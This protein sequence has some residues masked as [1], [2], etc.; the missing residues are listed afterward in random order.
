MAL[1][2]IVAALGF[3]SLTA[4][5]TVAQIPAGGD[6]VGTKIE[7]NY[8]GRWLPAEINEIQTREGNKQ[9][10]VRYLEDNT[11][12]TTSAQY[13]RPLGGGSTKNRAAKPIQPPVKGRT[14]GVIPK[15]QRTKQCSILHDNDRTSCMRGWSAT[16]ES[17]RMMCASMVVRRYQT[18][19]STGVYPPQ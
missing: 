4:G 11:T 3:V 8:F 19:I 10:R 2:K 5:V 1:G 18:C 16:G 13:M 7:V 12:D 15:A 9:Y 14:S 17:N 6:Q